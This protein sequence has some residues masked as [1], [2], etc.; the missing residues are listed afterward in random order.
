MN[1]NWESLNGKK[2]RKSKAK[3]LIKFFVRHGTHSKQKP[4]EGNIFYFTQFPFWVLFTQKLFSHR[5]T[6]NERSFWFTGGRKNRE[7]TKSNTK[8]SIMM[9]GTKNGKERHPASV[10]GWKL[11]FSEI[12]RKSLML[13][14]HRHFD[15][16]FMWRFFFMFLCFI[17]FCFRHSIT[18]RYA[19]NSIIIKKAICEHGENELFFFS[20]GN[21]WMPNFFFHK[22]WR[23]ERG[24]TLLMLLLIHAKIKNYKNLFIN[25]KRKELGMSQR[26]FCVTLGFLI[27]FDQKCSA[28]KLLKM[29]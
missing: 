4:N 3:S 24:K 25:Q 9:M 11:K 12:E 14:T 23:N 6:I 10:G 20:R 13:L 1:R 28:F 21:F 27:M 26:H 15:F 18:T 2:R 8:D 29:F 17:F 5:Q 16:S 19:F 7:R 22:N